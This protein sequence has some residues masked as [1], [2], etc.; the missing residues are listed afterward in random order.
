[1]I[2]QKK[3]HIAKTISYRVVS[4]ACGFLAIFITT[5][6]Y[7]IGAAFTFGELVFKP[8]LYYF[9]ERFW[10]KQIKFGLNPDKK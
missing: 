9:H 6:S 8:I 7:R 1:M 2:I 3:R 10:Y 5:G 4:S